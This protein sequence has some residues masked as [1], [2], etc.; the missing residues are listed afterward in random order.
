MSLFEIATTG[1]AIAAAGAAV[2]TAWRA[3]RWRKS[4]DWQ[5]MRNRVDKHETRLALVERDLSKI[6][7]KEDLARLEGELS[8]VAAGVAAANAGVDRI[9]G[10][11]LKR[12][13][14]GA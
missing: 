9:E 2:F 11:L 3:E 12:A 8:T 14:G 6:P 13:L 7:T 1:A 10:L 5:A 4:E